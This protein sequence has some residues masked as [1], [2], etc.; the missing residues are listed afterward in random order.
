[1]IALY[2]SMVESEADKNKVITIY[3]NYHSLMCY[4]AGKYLKNT[5]DIE[6]VVHTAMLKII[7]NLSVFDVDDAEHTKNLCCLIARQK[8]IDFCRSRAGK[9]GAED[10]ADCAAGDDS[11][12]EHIVI[13]KDTYDTILRVIE[14]LSVTYKD[15]CKLKYVEGLKEREIAAL[16]D[17]SPKTVNQRIQRGK[18]LIRAA[19]REEG[20]HD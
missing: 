1:M 7:E 5:Y 16:L 19:L 10:E 3:E 11:D 6:D 20:L 2:L 13:G 4:V 12:P 14:S 15:V 8:A 18:Q 9:T 17:L